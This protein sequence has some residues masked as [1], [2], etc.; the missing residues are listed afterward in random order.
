MG[1][2][3]RSKSGRKK[4]REPKIKS[5]EQGSFFL[6]VASRPGLEAKRYNTYNNYTYAQKRN[7]FCN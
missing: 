7:S 5:K 6:A 2:M 4:V 1:F 3:E